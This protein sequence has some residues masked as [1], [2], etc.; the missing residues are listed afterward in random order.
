METSE[1][2]E[3]L[4]DILKSMMNEDSPIADVILQLPNIYLETKF[5]DAFEI[6]VKQVN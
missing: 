5:G 4:V 1:I 6:T 2:K 3:M